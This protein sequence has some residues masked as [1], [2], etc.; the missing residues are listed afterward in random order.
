MKFVAA[1]FVSLFVISAFAEDYTVEKY[2]GPIAAGQYDGTAAHAQLDRPEAVARDGMGNL[3]VADSQDL[4]VRKIATNGEVSTVAGPE[5]SVGG[6]LES[7]ASVNG[8]AVDSRGVVFGADATGGQVWRIATTGVVSS[9][10]TIGSPRALAID[11]AG[12]VYVA[13]GDHTVSR[14]S[15]GACER[16]L[17]VR[18]TKRERAT[19]PAL[20]HAFRASYRSLSMRTTMYSSST[21]A[22]REE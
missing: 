6:S 14:V 11:S 16:S 20:L 10:V 15:P 3:Y 21:T 5:F 9:F 13:G 12:N 4:V 22:L 18:R 1:L 17:P 7:F 8:I 2:L 19:V